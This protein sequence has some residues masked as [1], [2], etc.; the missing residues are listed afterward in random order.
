MMSIQD[1]QICVLRYKVN[2][3]VRKLEDYLVPSTYSL[4]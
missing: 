1:E 3:Q 4:Q 2:E